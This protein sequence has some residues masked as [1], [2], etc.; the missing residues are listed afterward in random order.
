MYW[1]EGIVAAFGYSGKGYFIMQ[2]VQNCW[3]AEII[4]C[5]KTFIQYFFFFLHFKIISRQ[6]NLL[7][8]SQLST[9]TVPHAPISSRH[10]WIYNEDLILS[11][12]PFFA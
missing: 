7:S 8:I 3:S 12:S 5:E 1:E 4:K 11:F 6:C 2:I 9:S 10:R